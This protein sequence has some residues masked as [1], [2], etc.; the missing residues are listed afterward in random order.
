MNLAP[1]SHHLWTPSSDQWLHLLNPASHLKIISWNLRPS[2]LILTSWFVNVWKK[3]NFI[4]HK[5]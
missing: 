5:F 1:P 3:F 4:S 2:G